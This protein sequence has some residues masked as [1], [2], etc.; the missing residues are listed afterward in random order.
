MK[1]TLLVNLFSGPGALKSGTAGGVF[2]LLKLHGVDVDLPYEFPKDMV[3]E[4]QHEAF[5]DQNFLFGN[6]FHRLW[7]VRGKVDVI[8]CDSPILFS[9]VYRRDEFSED[10]YN[11]VVKSHLTFNNF[12]IFLERDPN[13]PYEENGRNETFEQAKEVDL[14]MITMLNNTIGGDYITLRS[15]VDTINQ[16]AKMVL[17]KLEKKLRFKIMEI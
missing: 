8:V 12:N 3:W 11:N 4:L 15:S 16:I 13:I 2:T 10:F 6:Q 7:R 5:D 1:E 14:K 17:F 9:L